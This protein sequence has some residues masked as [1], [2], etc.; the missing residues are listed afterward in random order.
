[1]ALRCLAG[2]FIVGCLLGLLLV[3]D[4]GYWI[5]LVIALLGVTFWFVGGC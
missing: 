4:I 5:S 1:M 3:L 2:L